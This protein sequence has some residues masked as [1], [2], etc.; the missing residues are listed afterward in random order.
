MMSLGLLLI[1]G[2]LGIVILLG[3]GVGVIYI[4]QSSRRDTVSSAREDWLNRR[5]EKDNEAG[6]S[7]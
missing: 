4:I 6:D 3:L 5:S 2:C 7:D 1:L